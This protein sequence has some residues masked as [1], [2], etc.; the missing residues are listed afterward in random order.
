KALA[1][2]V[3]DTRFVLDRLG[4]PLPGG[5]DRALDLSRVGM[6]G[7]SMG[8]TA[9]ALA[10]DADPRIRAGIDMDRNLPEFDRSLMPLAEHGLAGPFVLMGKDGPT[11]TGPG[12]D[13]FR[14]HT[15][16]WTRQL[17]LRGSEHAS[18]TDAEALLPQ[19]GL[20]RDTLVGDLG[21]IDPATAVRTEE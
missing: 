4:R 14:A 16:G 21:T 17:T 18:F 5:L 13:A 8:G 6:F 20:P 15:P 12:W 19:L 9:A 10:M 3:A 7:H 2:R 11:D 1:V